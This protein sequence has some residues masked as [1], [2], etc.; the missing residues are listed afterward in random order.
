MV[1]STGG[2]RPHFVKCEVESHVTVTVQTGKLLEFVHTVLPL[3]KLTD[4]VY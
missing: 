3:H 4:R 1:K 2:K